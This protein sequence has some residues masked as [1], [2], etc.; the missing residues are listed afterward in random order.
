MEW[1]GLANAGWVGTAGRG[2]V[3]AGWG[4]TVESKWTG[5][6]WL[7]L[8]WAGI[9][10]GF[11]GLSRARLGLDGLDNAGLLGWAWACAAPGL[12]VLVGVGCIA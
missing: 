9:G 4:R 1:L 12:A 3:A 10:Q 6:E 7:S 8:A 5:V 11:A 2:V